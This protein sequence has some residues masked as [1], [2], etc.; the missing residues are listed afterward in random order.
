MCNKKIG[1]FGH[2]PIFYKMTRFILQKQ[3]KL[4]YLINHLHHPFLSSHSFCHTRL[5]FSAPTS[6][7]P[8]EVNYNAITYLNNLHQLPYSF[9][10]FLFLLFF[11][12]RFLHIFSLCDS[13]SLLS[14]DSVPLSL[15]G[16]FLSLCFHDIQLFYSVSLLI[17]LLSS[18][19]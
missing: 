10:L 13:C 14:N 19:L 5:P 15:L 16:S 12:H 6:P 2:I 17:F 3:K 9:S 7:I 8:V 4:T 1:K 18:S 11:L